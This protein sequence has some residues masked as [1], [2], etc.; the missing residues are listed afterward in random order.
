MDLKDKVKKLP[1]SPGVYLMKDSLGNVIYVGKSKNLKN[2]VRSYFQNLKS[3]SSKIMRL[4]KNIEDFDYI[5]TDT[6]F[7]AFILECKLIKKIKPMYNKQMKNPKSYSYIKISINERYPGIEV[8]DELVENDG[9]V[10]FGPYKSR[11]TVEKGLQGIKECCKILCS[12]NS[13]KISSCLNYSLGLCIGICLDSTPKEQYLTI[14]NKIIKL[15]NGT[16]KSILEKM[17]YKMS[18]F[19][20]KLDFKNAAK[21]RDYISSVNYLL[22][23][24]KVIKFTEKN[25]NIAL[26]EY[27]NDNKAKFFLIKGNKLLFN[28]KYIIKDFGFENLKSI[29]RANILFYFN[30]KNAGNSIKIGKEEIDESQIVYT[31]LKNKS[32][33]CKYVIILKKWINASDSQNI[34]NELDKL[35]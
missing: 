11:N 34:D 21:Y 24:D 33:N 27:L 26:L 15:L 31:Y 7:E 5:L 1:S 2:R 32:N 13:P 23:N 9:T 22:H 12:S 4:I 28:K 14:L 8:S 6:E 16:D 3:H 29:F 17:K 35:F 25:R 18:I 20:E 10:Y 19:S 30:N